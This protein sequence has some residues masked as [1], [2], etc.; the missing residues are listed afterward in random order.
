[1]VLTVE[2]GPAQGLRL[3]KGVLSLPPVHVP[4][5]S[6][7]VSGKRRHTIMTLNKLRKVELN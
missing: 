7:S 2:P 1:M 5:L 3:L 6:L 4:G